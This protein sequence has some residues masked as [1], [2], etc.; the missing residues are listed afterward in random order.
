MGIEYGQVTTLAA[1]IGNASKEVTAKASVVIRKT[2][3]I[4]EGIM[5]VEVPV[6]TGAL[7]NSVGVDYGQLTATIGPTVSYAPYVAFGT[8]RM[9]ANPYD[10]RTADRIGPIFQQ[11][12]ERIGGELLL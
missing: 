2:G 3:A 11:A 4:A 12:M 5:K 10:L 9:A 7:R 8:R 1:D 6:D